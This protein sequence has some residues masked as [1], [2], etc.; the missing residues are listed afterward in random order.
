MMALV[1]IPAVAEQR[2]KTSGTR[3]RADGAIKHR[4]H[5][6]RRDKLHTRCSDAD[7]SNSSIIR[8]FPKSE[9][10]SWR[11]ADRR[12][13]LVLVEPA[14]SGSSKENNANKSN[15]MILYFNPFLHV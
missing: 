11:A 3:R 4:D 1:R 14:P 7:H 5:K 8:F 6:H 15:V 2:T 13:P 9:R 12:Q 10:K